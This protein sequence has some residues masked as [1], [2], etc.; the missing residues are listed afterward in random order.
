[1]LMGCECYYLRIVV[2]VGCGGRWDSTVRKLVVVR[3]VVHHLL[4]DVSVNDV[5]ACNGELF[6]V[7]LLCLSVIRCLVRVC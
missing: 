1:V 6:S 7:T 4:W 2:A 5:K 3:C